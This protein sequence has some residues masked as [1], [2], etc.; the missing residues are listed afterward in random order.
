[1]S[2]NGCPTMGERPFTIENTVTIQI[3]IQRPQDILQVYACKSLTFW[4]ELNRERPYR[5]LRAL[6][7]TNAKQANIKPASHNSTWN[8]PSWTGT[9][10]LFTITTSW[11]GLSPIFRTSSLSIYLV[12]SWSFRSFGRLRSHWWLHRIPIVNLMEIGLYT[13]CFPSSQGVATVVI[14]NWLP[15]NQL[16][17]TISIRLYLCQ[18]L[19]ACK[20]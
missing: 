6:K 10:P 4:Y 2:R 9:S 20:R 11:T 3:Y 14:K 18:R 1:M 16:N 5:M 13:T 15:Y 7:T 8:P 19:P 12:L 17:S